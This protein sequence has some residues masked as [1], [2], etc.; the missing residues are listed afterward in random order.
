M[1]THD[2]GEAITMSKRVIVLSCAAIS[3]NTI[4][5]TKIDILR[6]VI[7]IFLFLMFFKYNSSP[8]KIVKSLIKFVNEGTL[9]RHIWVTC[10]ETIL[11]SNTLDA[12]SDD[13]NKIAIITPR[14][15]PNKS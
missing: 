12:V 10:Y 9:A 8:S 5:I 2:L 6:I 4:N 1:V 14:T 7:L 15:V 11:G 13:H 3:H